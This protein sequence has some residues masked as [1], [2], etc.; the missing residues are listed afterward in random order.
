MISVH[1]PPGTK[2][3]YVWEP[4]S[5]E[6][7]ALLVEPYRSFYTVQ[8]LESQ[9]VLGQTYTVEA[10]V[11]A[12]FVELGFAVKIQGLESFWSLQCFNNVDLP[13]VFTDLL[14]TVKEPEDA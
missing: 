6:S 11:E 12:H 14:E 3:V 10:I 1:T 8:I 4:T 5:E 2:V 13:K 9:L 7:R